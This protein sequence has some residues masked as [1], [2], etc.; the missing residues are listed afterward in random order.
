LKADLLELP[1]FHYANS[2][3]ITSEISNQS[4]QYKVDDKAINITTKRGVSVIWQKS[5][6]QL[7]A[8]FSV[9]ITG[10]PRYCP[11]SLTSSF[12]AVALFIDALC[13]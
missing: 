6:T 7:S 12:F 13:I 1:G 9:I 2:E 5:P 4:H 3:Q 10:T 8:T 11:P